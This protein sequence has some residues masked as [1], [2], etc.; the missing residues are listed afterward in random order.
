MTSRSFERVLSEVWVFAA[1][2]AVAFLATDVL[3][4]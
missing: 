1:F 3:F 2:S 4:R